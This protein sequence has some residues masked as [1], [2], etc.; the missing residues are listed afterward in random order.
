LAL[1]GGACGLGGVAVLVGPGAS[2]GDIWAVLEVLG[3]AVCY[4]TGPVIVSRKLGNADGLGVTAACLGFAAVI[5]ALPAAL[6]WPQAVPPARVLGAL[7]GLAVVCTA[8][9]FVLYFKLIAEAGPARATVITYVNP[10]VAVALG[11]MVLG[12]PVTPAIVISFAL[13]LAGSV[14]ATRSTGHL[15]RTPRSKTATGWASTAGSSRGSPS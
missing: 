15:T 10:A 14:L 1:A 11:A 5:Y 7:A 4:A 12:E 6:T 9:A 2:G 8:L 3:T 13:I